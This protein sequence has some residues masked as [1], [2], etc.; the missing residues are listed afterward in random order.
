VWHSKIQLLP[1]CY[2][3]IG[4]GPSLLASAGYIIWVLVA[5][6]IQHRVITVYLSWE[7]VYI[8]LWEMSARIQQRRKTQKA[9]LL[10]PPLINIV[11]SPLSL[12]TR[13]LGARPGVHFPHP[14]LIKIRTQRPGE[15]ARQIIL[16]S[17]IERARKRERLINLISSDWVFRWARAFFYLLFLYM[18]C[19]NRVCEEAARQSCSLVF[20]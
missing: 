7:R 15:I 20:I 12:R 9:T 10:L 8:T 6:S 17:E 18:I 13:A 3:D 4:N 11:S 5:L 19:S 2:L 1:K 14:S 16:R